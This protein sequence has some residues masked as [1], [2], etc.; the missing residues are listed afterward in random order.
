[1]KIIYTYPVIFFTGLLVLFIHIGSTAQ[2]NYRTIASGNWNGASTWE[3]DAAG[4]GIYSSTST[5]P[6]SSNS[7]SIL[8]NTDHE[9]TVPA[10]YTA[11]IDETIVDVSG[12]ITVASTAI[13]SVIDGSGSDLQFNTDGVDYGLMDVSGTLSCANGALISNTTSSNLN[14]L[15]GGIYQHNYV[16]TEGS[17]PLANWDANSTCQILGYTTAISASS[18]G[19]WDQAFGHFL[20]N[21]SLASNAIVNL[22]GKL[23]SIA[24]DLTISGTGAANNA[25]R[26]QLSTTQ[27]PAIAIGGNL[28]ISNSSRV[29]FATTTG[30]TV[31]V[32]GNFNYNSTNTTASILGTNGSTT[33]NVNGNFSM[34]ASGGILRLST[35]TG[36]GTLK[37]K[38]NFALTAGTI[39]ETSAGTSITGAIEFNGTTTQ[40][41][42]NAGSINNSI[43]YTIK[44]LAIVDL[45][46]SS[47]TGAGTFLL[48]SG[49]TVRL[50]SL[51]AFGAIQS[52]TTNGNIRVPVVGRT[53]QAGANITF[54]GTSAQSLGDAYPNTAVNLTINNSHNVSITGAQFTI[55]ASATLTL[56]NGNLVIGPN[57][58]V[59]QGS[60][61]TGSG[62]INATSAS[63][64]T[65]NT[66]GAFGTIPFDGT[67]TEIGGLTLNCSSGGSATLGADIRVTTLLTLTQGNLV[68]NG[69]TFKIS[70]TID[71]TITNTGKISGN[72]SSSITIEE[73]ASALGT[74]V[75]ASGGNSIQNLTLDRAAGATLGSDAT[76]NSTLAL[77]NGALTIS[78]GTLTLANGASLTRTSGSIGTVPTAAGSYNVTYLAANT[79]GNELPTGSTQLN[80]LTINPT[81]GTVT[82]N[83]AITVNGA[84]TISTGTFS[85]SGSNYAI[86]VKGNWT[87]NSTFTANSNTTTFSGSTLQTIGGTQ[88][89]TFNALTI[90][91]SSGVTFSGSGIT[92]TVGGIL[93][94]SSGALII[95]S[96][97]LALNSTISTTSG[98][99]TGGSTSNITFN[100]SGTTAMP[101]V[102]GGLN[103]LA[104]NRSGTVT[105]GGATT[106]TGI[107]TLTAG[108]FASGGNLNINLNTGAISGTGSGAITG[109]ISVFK[110]VSSSRYHY[111]SS[112]L[113]GT[114]AAQLDDDVPITPNLYYYDETNTSTNK[115]TGWTSISSTSTPLN[116]L[117][118][119]NLYFSGTTSV[120][121]T[122]GYTHGATPSISLSYTNSGNSS[123]DGWHLAGNPY[124]SPVDWD[125]AS[126]TKTNINDAIFYWNTASSSY[127]TYI[128]GAGTNGGTNIIPAMQGFWVNCN[129][130]AGTLGITNTARTTSSIPALFKK[131][132]QQN[133]LRLSVQADGSSF[134]D[135]TVIRFDSSATLGFDGKK[136][137]GKLLNPSGVP[138]IYSIL[139]NKNYVINTLPYLNDAIQV[140]LKITGSADGQYTISATELGTFDSTFGGIYLVDRLLN[141]MQ[142]L[143]T[144][145][146]YS[147]FIST[148]DTSARFYINFTPNVIANLNNADNSRFYVTSTDNV[149]SL[150]CDNI[151]SNSGS[152]T[153]TNLQGSQVFEVQEADLSKRATTFHTGLDTGLYII[154][155]VTDNKVFVKKIFLNK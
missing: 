114:T 20:I 22:N 8:I 96:N 89:T 85:T 119:Y 52:N 128:N 120:D 37:V 103:N 84:L 6:S 66:S 70:G 61:A 144:D 42:V 41:F 34:N 49:G 141:K 104:I 14:F 152:V 127:S 145:P 83:S 28:N 95:G 93:G 68:I 113:S 132:A 134:K 5:A 79:T 62:F 39:E 88:A 138:S 131:A 10:G 99:L 87:N 24:G 31:T 106:V 63:S 143:L 92:Y 19:N 60:I 7:I 46:T 116:T 53:Y 124:P 100:G 3:K 109:N 4:N 80:N 11:I 30:C 55:L 121:F 97:T 86:A 77:T 54:N 32:S 135:E 112:P 25:S 90:S 117:Q 1:M 2:D 136:D 126:W 98:T 76:I 153:I 155:I 122:S 51:D 27:G 102:S 154:K 65:I 9:V 73:N 64:L 38:G 23:T 18:G 71:G 44:N 129:S 45:G 81:T 125:A 142:N 26:V 148:A 15:S 74:L 151:K 17:I 57:I 40:T 21:C 69:R 133:F 36:V 13:L 150:A 12:K 101:A 16:S 115:N 75:L 33:I 149:I 35:G 94:L 111:I 29:V 139:N 59:I 72:T 82:L 91:N 50:G 130:A 78:G 108:T 118:G 56:T 67:T 140:P 123:A 47:V 58:L 107:V 43:S 48:E 137:A 146:Q 105:I 147:A 110:T